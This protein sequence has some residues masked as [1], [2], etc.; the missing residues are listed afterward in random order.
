MLHPSGDL[1]NEAPLVSILRLSPSSAPNL[2]TYSFTCLTHCESAKACMT[3][4]GLTA[5]LLSHKD[6]HSLSCE[7]GKGST[8]VILA[9]RSAKVRQLGT[10][11]NCFIL[12][13][14]LLL[15][16]KPKLRSLQ[17]V[18]SNT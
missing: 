9:E 1:L 2:K 17:C 13:Q 5:S 16:L 15:C 11:L 7:P 4:A 6:L 8:P 14:D 3:I 18:L 12:A 10:Q